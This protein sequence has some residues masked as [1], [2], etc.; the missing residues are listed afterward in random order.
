MKQIS[1]VRL[2]RGA[3]YGT[4]CGNT[5]MQ[6]YLRQFIFV[7]LA[8]QRVANRLHALYHNYQDYNRSD[9]HVHL[10]TLITV[11]DCQISQPS[12]A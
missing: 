1:G 5:D 11:T 8:A 2:N 9:H 7:Q 6:L 3:G 12:A 4:S 10:E